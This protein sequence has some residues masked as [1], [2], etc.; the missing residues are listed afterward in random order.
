MWPDK[1]RREKLHSLR[2]ATQSHQRQLRAEELSRDRTEQIADDICAFAATLTSGIENLDFAG[3]ER[4]VRLLVER[5][6]LKDDHVTIEHVVPLS[7]RFYGLRSADRA[8]RENQRTSKRQTL[9]LS[10]SPSLT[11]SPSLSLS[12]SLS[13]K[14]K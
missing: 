14:T 12:L 9:T 5:V 6:V 13:P 3:R 4:I 11:L 10:P 2:E 1:A 8:R 7:G